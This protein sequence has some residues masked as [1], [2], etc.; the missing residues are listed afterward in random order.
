MRAGD[1]QFY[2]ADDAEADGVVEV[3]MRDGGSDDEYRFP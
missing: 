3:E 2:D 1:G